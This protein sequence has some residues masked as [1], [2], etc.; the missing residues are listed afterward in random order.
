MCIRDS[1]YTDF[2]K[3]I[4][5][6]CIIVTLACGKFRF[7]ML[8]LGYVT[9]KGKKF[10]HVFDMGQCNDSYSALKFMVALSKELGV[11]ANDLPMSFVISWFEQK[12][13]AV[14]LTYLHF[15]IKNMLLGPTLPAF[16]PPDV[17]DV[18][19]KKFGL[20]RIGTPEADMQ[21]LLNRKS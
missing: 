5:K 9:I 11:P 13:V 8:D 14:F 21:M 16:T 6:D 1:Y 18:L 20:R 4:P 2:A 7:N 17:L 12:A 19:V 3:L 10:P 15:G